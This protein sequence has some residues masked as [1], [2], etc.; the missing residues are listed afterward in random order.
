MAIILANEKIHK[1]QTYKAIM[2]IDVG[3]N[4]YTQKF[5]QEML[6][7]FNDEDLER[8]R[9][10]DGS[11]VFTR[12]GDVLGFFSFRL[13]DTVDLYQ[14][15]DPPTNQWLLSYWIDQLVLA[16]PAEVDFIMVLNSPT[17]TGNK[18]AR[19][20]Y[21]GRIMKPAINRLEEVAIEDVLVE[22]EIIGFTS[23]LR[24]AT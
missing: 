22:G 1:T 19:I 24:E 3:G 21:K 17:S 6:I 14:T 13:K 2:Q 18:F 7:E 23:A 4:Q 5:I 11:P 15:V 16:T 10:D 20:R 12:I 8:V 9:I